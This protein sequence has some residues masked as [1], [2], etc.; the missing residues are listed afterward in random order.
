MFEKDPKKER[1][2][3]KAQRYLMNAK[4]IKK[5]RALQQQVYSYPACMT[6]VEIALEEMSK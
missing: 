5:K 6:A 2:R 1:A 3:R 4:N